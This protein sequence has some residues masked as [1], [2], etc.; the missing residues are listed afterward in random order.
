MKHM[1]L[2]FFPFLSSIS[3]HAQSEMNL[4]ECIQMALE[5]NPSIRNCVI[6]IKEAQTE[7]MASIGAFLP[8]ITANAEIG[9]H[10]G[11]SIAPDTNTYTTDNFEEGTASLN[12]TLSLFEGFSRI[13][14]VRFR[15]IKKEHSK[16]ELADKQNALAYQITD[17]Y[18]KLILEKHLLGLAGE[19]N[20][21][22][23]HYLKQTETFVEL[24]LKS[25]SDLQE[26]KARKEGDLYRYK[27][28]EN[29]YRLALS[30][31]KRLM[32]LKPDDILIVQDTI[33]TANVPFIPLPTAKTLYHRSVEILPSMRLI[34]LKQKAAHKE[35][36]MAEGA[37]YPSVFARATVSSNY[38]NT[39]FSAR[40]LHGNIGK[41][42][43][44]GISFPLLN[45]WERPTRLRKLKL[46]ISRMRNE[47][48]QEKRQL[49]T[50]IEQ[51]IL[52]LQAGYI[53]HRQALLHFNAE[54]L[55]LQESERKWEEGLISVFQLIESRNRLI[56]AKAELIR[57][58]LQIELMMKL[59][60]YYRQG[61]FL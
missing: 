42:F 5:R 17:A 50:S 3:L 11:R 32:N 35:Y 57:V 39:F 30:H 33:T 43:G 52:S 49:Y 6:G 29:S 38:Y 58:R 48:E 4:D 10:F 53:E 45:G 60:K 22:S 20:R 24:G 40:Q 2:L 46:N 13:N 51:T 37:F 44:I 12:M 7:Y 26:M 25:V 18:Y 9:K 8:R 56:A 16:W 19:Q 23:E 1:L 27:S 15:K 55:V 59:E 47:K 21:L 61:T 31:L 34:D 14:R 28:R 41:Y 36:A 54:R